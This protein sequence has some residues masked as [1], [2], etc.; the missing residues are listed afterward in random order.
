[1]KHG[2][3]APKQK[4]SSIPYVNAFKFVEAF[5]SALIMD[6]KAAVEIHSKLSIKLSLLPLSTISDNLI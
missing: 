4:H 3:K 1:M 5:S 2:K 6:M